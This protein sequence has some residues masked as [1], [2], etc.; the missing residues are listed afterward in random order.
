M[1][2]KLE[3]L[4]VVVSLGPHIRP[5]FAEVKGTFGSEAVPLSTLDFRPSGHV[6]AHFPMAPADPPVLRAPPFELGFDFLA[7]ED[8]DGVQDL[9]L[10]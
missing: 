6:P 1:H 7:L 8:L 9:P 3:I 5:C 10:P 2:E 4:K